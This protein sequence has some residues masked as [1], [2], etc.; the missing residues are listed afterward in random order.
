MLG[1]NGVPIGPFVKDFNDKTREIAA[2]YPGAVVKVPA[3]ITV[4]ADKSYDLDIGTPL[5]SH[6][7]LR[8]V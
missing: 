8:K 5:T 6:L 7:L 2:K 4:Y 3:I 1:Q